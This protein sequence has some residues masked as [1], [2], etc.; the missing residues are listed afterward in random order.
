M[1]LPR[2]SKTLHRGERVYLRR[3]AARDCKEVTHTGR[4]SRALHRPWVFPPETPEAFAEYLRR[5]RRHDFVGF[6]IC[7]RSDERMVGMANLSQ[8]FRGGFQNAYLG[9]WVSA[10]FGGQGLMTEGLG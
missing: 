5:T 3:P 7:H 10:E 6:L 9:F 2:R 4:N 1:I 8:L